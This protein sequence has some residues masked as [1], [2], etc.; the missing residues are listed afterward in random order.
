MTH[1]ERQLTAIA[2]VEPDRIPVDAIHIEN[3]PE[4]AAHLGIAAD[5]VLERLGLDGRAVGVGY[6]GALPPPQDGEPLSEWGTPA[7]HDYGT[8]HWYPLADAATSADLARH[9]WPDPARYD[10]AGAAAAA[11]ALHAAYA[12]RGPYWVPLFCRVCSLAGMEA[13][14]VSLATDPAAFE[15]LLDAVFA[16]VAEICR[17]FVHACGDSLDI[18]CLG[19]DFAT[20]RGMLFEPALWRRYLKPR[21][22]ELFALGKRAGKPVWFH[23]CGDIT[24]I[25]PD[26][27]DIGMDVWET[28]QLHT[29]PLSPAVLKREY[30]RHLAFFGAVNTQRLPFATPA[31]V[32]AE[33]AACCRTLGRGGGYICGPDHHVKPDVPPANVVALF[34]AATGFRPAPAATP[35]TTKP[36]RRLPTCN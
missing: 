1:R 10:Y 13:T 32:A 6:L 29:L 26:L 5:A 34:A 28:V 2:H 23:S 15:A 3:V 21:L 14:L 18:L 9:A 30:G 12:V 7:Q 17:R 20:Q 16:R 19:D 4:I 25:L 35:R 31:E 27:I 22:A 36:K 24:A 8:G 33:V 11:A